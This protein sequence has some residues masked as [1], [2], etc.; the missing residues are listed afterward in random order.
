MKR[1][2]AKIDIRHLKT[3]ITLFQ[4]SSLSATS[5][6]NNSTVSAVS[7]QLKALEEYLGGPLFERKKEGLCPTESAMN[8]VHRIQDINISF[9][10]LLAKARAKALAVNNQFAIGVG[11]RGHVLAAKGIAA[12]KREFTSA[13]IS[14]KPASTEQQINDLLSGNITVGFLTPPV[15]PPLKSFPVGV[16]NL[17]LVA[18][19]T[20][21]LTKNISR[22]ELKKIFASRP[23]IRQSPQIDPHIYHQIDLFLYDKG[24]TSYSVDFFHD[25]LALFSMIEEMGAIAI[26][27]WSEFLPH[28]DRLDYISLKGVNSSWP[29]SLAWNPQMSNVLTKHFIQ[30]YKI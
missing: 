24:I 22:H 14:L 1:I 26:I 27:P 15:P 7:K 6:T 8:I 28:S 16:G 9:D 3:F 29:V 5:Q 25:Q 20:Q 12:I 11:S 30:Q 19:R 4:T 18:P 13:K 23:F 21:K 2:P 17:V 10:K